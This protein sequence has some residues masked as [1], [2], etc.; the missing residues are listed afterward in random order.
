MYLIADWESFESPLVQDVA[1]PGCCVLS[2]FQVSPPHFQGVRVSEKL[3]F[4]EQI[5]IIW[6]QVVETGGPILQGLL[7]N[8]RSHYMRYMMVLKGASPWLHSPYAHLLADIRIVLGVPTV[9]LL[10]HPTVCAYV[11]SSIPIHASWNEIS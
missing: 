11:R 4:V 1:L 7:R 6:L 10:Q 2:G 8:S 3:F 5:I 9:Q